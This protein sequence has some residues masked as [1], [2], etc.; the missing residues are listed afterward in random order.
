MAFTFIRCGILLLLFLPQALQAQDILPLQV[1]FRIK[2][3]GMWVNGS[4]RQPQGTFRYAT[5]GALEADVRIPVRTISTGI[6]A[7]DRHLLK[8][9]YFDA[10]RFPTMQFVSTGWTAANASTGTL[11]GKLTI[12]G[13]TRPIQVPVQMAS[14]ATGG[15]RL[16]ARFTI[17]RRDFGVGD[18]SWLL[19]DDV[20]V[21]LQADVP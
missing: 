1:D 2:N 19:S 10:E 21:T 3:A 16:T 6:G 18:N 4:L 7:R 20:T 12:K 14:L 11:S 13:V 9:D 8:P 5:G 17:N 15:T